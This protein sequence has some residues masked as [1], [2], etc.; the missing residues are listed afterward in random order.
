ML[1][2]AAGLSQVRVIL[3]TPG[4]ARKLVIAD[5]E[6]SISVVGR[7]ELLLG[8]FVSPPPQA[9]SATENRMSNRVDKIGRVKTFDCGARLDASFILIDLY[10]VNT[11]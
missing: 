10:I 4:I 5:D 9:L 2:F 8:F 11:S 3:V 6:I 1:I 7:V